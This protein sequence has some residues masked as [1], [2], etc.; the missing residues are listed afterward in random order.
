MNKSSDNISFTP[1]GLK[2][3]DSIGAQRAHT[4]I[5][6]MPAPFHS[7]SL[8]PNEVVTGNIVFEAPQG[9]ESFKLVYEPIASSNETATV[10]L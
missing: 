6:E 2:L 10:N 1:F 7:G 8:S 4:I 3:V 9:D 5:E